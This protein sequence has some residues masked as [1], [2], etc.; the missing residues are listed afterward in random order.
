MKIF[1][2][3]IQNCKNVIRKFSEK[4]NINENEIFSCEIPD[5]QIKDEIIVTS[6]DDNIQINDL[7]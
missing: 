3:P 6:T 2:L 4:Y 5:N 1:G 7:N